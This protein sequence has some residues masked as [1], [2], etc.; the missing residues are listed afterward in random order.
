MQLPRKSTEVQELI[1]VFALCKLTKLC[2]VCAV[3]CTFC[4]LV[5]HAVRATCSSDITGFQIQ[6]I[7]INSQA[8]LYNS[9]KPA[10]SVLICPSSHEHV[11][12]LASRWSGEGQGGV[13]TTSRQHQGG[14]L[15]PLLRQPLP[16]ASGPGWSAMAP[17]H[18]SEPT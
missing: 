18:R 15:V 9:K 14:A 11:P 13:C 4:Y 16:G 12:Y 2:V 8:T 5:E 17:L 1:Q 3:L 7:R 6:P 10:S